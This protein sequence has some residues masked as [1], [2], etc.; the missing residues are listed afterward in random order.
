M[1]GSFRFLQSLSL[2]KWAD[3]STY[4]FGYLC[5]GCRLSWDY[6]SHLKRNVQGEGGTL[7]VAFSILSSYLL[8]CKS[9]VLLFFYCGRKLITNGTVSAENVSPTSRFVRVLRAPPNRWSRPISRNVGIG[10]CWY[11]L[12]HPCV[13]GSDWYSNRH[14]TCHRC[15]YPPFSRQAA[16][17]KS[18]WLA[19]CKGW[20]GWCDCMEMGSNDNW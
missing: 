19:K 12:I 16:N 10:D 2:L 8:E 20:L 18:M 9:P 6:F 5:W 4:K 15:W 13:T 17:N 3:I 11:S 14:Q 7:D 1:D